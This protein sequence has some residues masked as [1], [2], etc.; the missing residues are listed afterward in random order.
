MNI[1]DQTAGYLTAIRRGVPSGA[2]TL[3]LPSMASTPLLEIVG[4]V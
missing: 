4:M 1:V 3:R 2:A